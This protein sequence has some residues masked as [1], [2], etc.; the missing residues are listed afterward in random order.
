M[1]ARDLEAVTVAVFRCYPSNPWQELIYRNFRERGARIHIL[2]DA[3]DLGWA[4]EELLSGRRVALHFNWTAQVS[5]T[6]PSL[7]DSMLTVD[8]VLAAI[9]AFLGGGG[10]LIW[11]VHNVLPRELRYYWP[12]VALCR[13]LA[14]HTDAIH[15]MNPD[16]AAL[17]REHCELPIGKV[18]VIDHPSYR[19]YFPDTV[20]RQSARQHFG[21]DDSDVAL[22]LLGTLR[23][24][25]RL[26]DL[27]VCIQNN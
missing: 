25:K 17:I 5:Q 4:P 1:P 11:V 19:G 14:E 15:V 20:S 10:R 6:A 13:G 7:L 26:D 2:N 8:A 12:E 21:L 9:D 18:T 16:S 27:V 24:Y 23:L 3:L 22:L